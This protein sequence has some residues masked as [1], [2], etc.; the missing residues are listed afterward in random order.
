[1]SATPILA[2][3]DS[4]L[5]RDWQEQMPA[6]Q[7]SLPLADGRMPKSLGMEV[8]VVMVLDVNLLERLGGGLGDIPTLLVGQ[9]HSQPFEQARLEGKA[10]VYLSY[11][12]SRTRLK[13]F[14]PLLIEIADRGAALKLTMDR[15]RRPTVDTPPPFRTPVLGDNLDIWDFLEGAVENLGSRERLLAEFRRASRYLLRASHAVFFLREKGGFRADRGESFCGIDDPMVVYLG[16]HPA[17]FDGVDWPGPPNPVAELAVRHR[18]AMWG[19]RL[20]VPMHDNGKLVGMIAFGVRDDGQP[21]DRADHG[22]AVFVARLLRQ[23]L[24]QSAQLTTL[25]EQRDKSRVAEPYLPQSVVLGPDES[26]G[27]QVPLAIRALIGESR[28]SGKPERLYPQLDQPFRAGAGPITETGGTWACWEESSDEV[29][30]Q[31]QKGKESRLDLLR[32]LALTVNHEVSNALVSLSALKHAQ[33]NATPSSPML[34]AA[35]ADIAKLE[36]LNRSMVRLSTLT[37]VEPN[38]VEMRKF[39]QGLGQALGVQVEV[40]PDEVHLPIAEELLKFALESIIET[41]IENRMELERK[42]LTL[43]LRSTGDGPDLTAL[44]SIKGDQLELEGVLPVPATDDVP[45]Q[46]RIGVF[47]SR[48]VIR[49]HDGEIHAG[50]GMKGTEILIS[51][52]AWK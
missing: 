12:Q 5:L 18:L 28:R 1:M 22:R 49:M 37:E 25:V 47:I 27:N 45:N 3:E 11:E 43:Q 8:P 39:L 40:A 19:A 35:I 6:G 4:D 46:G 42:D 20:L 9:P 24:S 51:I 34:S 2:T 44:V 48:E 13:E 50:P 38:V 21:F 52:C 33:A 14:L 31:T 36:G 29:S 16:Q 32:N 41:V 26:A 7:L 15:T 10:L 23:F 30:D 17:V